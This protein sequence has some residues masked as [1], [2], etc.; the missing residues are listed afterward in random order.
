MKKYTISGL[1]VGVIA[2]VIFL[3]GKFN[4]IGFITNFGIIGKIIAVPLHWLDFPVFYY[5]TSPVVIVMIKISTLTSIPMSSGVIVTS[6]IWL[7]FLGTAIGYIIGKLFG[8]KQTP[9]N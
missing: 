8:H 4:G 5:L 3:I 1:I 2:G 9:L 7:V 6:F